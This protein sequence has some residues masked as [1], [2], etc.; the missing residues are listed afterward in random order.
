VTPSLA[1]ALH[2]LVLPAWFPEPGLPEQARFF[3]DQARALVQAGHRVGVIYPALRRPAQLDRSMFSRAPFAI[4]A[5]HEGELPVLQS[6][7]LHVPRGGPIN[8]WLFGQQ[9]LRL[10]HRYEAQHG[11][12]DVIHAQCSM[13]S[14]WGAAKIAEHHGVPFIVTEHWSGF[15]ERPLRGWRR[16]AVSF[17]LARA[18][19][20]LAVSR[21][22]ASVMQ[23][24]NGGRAVEVLAN[25][26]DLAQFRPRQRTAAPSGMRV[27]CIG[28]LIPRKRFDLAIAAF[29]RAFGADPTCSLEI[30][31]DGVEASKLRA[32]AQAIGIGERVL[33]LGQA[34]RDEVIAA[35]QRADLL[36]SSSAVETFGVVLIEALASGVPVVATRSGGPDDIVTPEVGF[37][38]A[39]GDASSLADALRAARRQWHTQGPAWGA[40]CSEYAEREYG[41]VQFAHRLEVILRRA[42]ERPHAA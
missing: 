36:V 42:L 39:P 16:A 2:V 23:P 4:S 6:H 19:A 15:L 25:T 9:A 7:G 38:A 8:P 29:A 13:W 22:L 34:S 5:R 20:V 1:A 18:A 40:R 24:L 31:G 12:P 14:A 41:S 37:L 32:L 11:R 10:Y 26:V 21:A 27:L 35:L 30:A 3:V 28:N 17:G 33:F